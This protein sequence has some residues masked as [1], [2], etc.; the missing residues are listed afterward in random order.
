RHLGVGASVH[1]GHV[2]G[3]V[4]QAQHGVGLDLADRT[5]VL[6]DGSPAVAPASQRIAVSAEATAPL[7][8][9]TLWVDAAPLAVFDALPYTAYWTL[10][11][12][13]HRFTVSGVT[14]EGAPVAGDVITVTVE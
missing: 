5:Q 7:H 6:H 10:A 8:E 4:E 1:L 14:P 2:A 12:G 3:E 9:V 13:P 11:P